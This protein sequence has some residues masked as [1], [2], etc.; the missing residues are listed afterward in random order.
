MRKTPGTNDTYLSLVL[1]WLK[2]S[3]FLKVYKIDALDHGSAQQRVGVFIV[4]SAVDIVLPVKIE[5]TLRTPPLKIFIQPDLCNTSLQQLTDIKRNNLVMWAEHLKEFM[6]D[7]S[8]L[9]QFAVFDVCRRPGGGFSSYYIDR[10]MTLTT[11]NIDIWVMSLG[12]GTDLTKLTVSRYLQ[13]N[14]RAILQGFPPHVCDSL[15]RTFAT[16]AIGNSFSPPVIAALLEQ[17]W[18]PMFA[19]SNKRRRTHVCSFD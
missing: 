16:H 7:T 1:G 6:E 2:E 15:S 9:G 17:I 8:R 11:K 12:E 4:G 14:E 3:F 13:I 10:I 18:V 19:V 5:P